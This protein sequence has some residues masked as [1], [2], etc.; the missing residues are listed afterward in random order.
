MD[1]PAQEAQV[2]CPVNPEQAVLWEQA[3]LVAKVDQ[4]ARVAMA[5]N[6]QNTLTDNQF[7][8]L[9]PRDV[10]EQMARTVPQ[11]DMETRDKQDPMVAEVTMAYQVCRGTMEETELTVLMAWFTMST[12]HMAC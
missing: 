7:S 3:G 12:T 11:A 9:N 8:T 1:L 6:G 4:A 5:L 10:L 2:A